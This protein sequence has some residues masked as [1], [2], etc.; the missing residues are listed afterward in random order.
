MKAVIQRVRSASVEVGEQVVGQIANGLLVLLGVAKGD[1][2]QDVAYMVEKIPHLRI[3]SD[4]AGKMNRSLVEVAGELLVVSQFTLL[5]DTRRGR[6]PGFDGAAPPDLAQQL[7]ELVIGRLKAQGLHVEAG[8]FGATM[9]I[10]LE[11]EGPVTFL[12][13]SR[14]SETDKMGKASTPG[15]R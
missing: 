14:R 10:K 3:F 4:S 7:Y 15:F 13:D 12:L 6:R 9:L 5:G 8:V 2:E 11:N 1:E